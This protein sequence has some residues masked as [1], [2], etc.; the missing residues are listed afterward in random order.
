M[1]GGDV[2]E[3]VDVEGCGGVSG[4]DYVGVLEGPF[5]PDVEEMS[6]DP[7][8]SMLGI[9]EEIQFVDLKNYLA[10]L[11]VYMSSNGSEICHNKNCFL[12]LIGVFWEVNMHFSGN[13][14]TANL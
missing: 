1:V 9:L 4:D 12:V 8:I 5:Q 14:R 6:P 13:S 11:D 10:C 2:V 7:A 3:T